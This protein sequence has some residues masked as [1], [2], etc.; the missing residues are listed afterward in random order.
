MTLPAWIGIPGAVLLIAFIVY[1]FR[2]GT[3][4]TTRQ[5]GDPPERDSP[6]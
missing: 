3:K 6:S 2:Q 4:V 1:G 5:E